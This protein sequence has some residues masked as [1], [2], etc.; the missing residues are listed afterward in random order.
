MPTEKI[1]VMPHRA[2]LGA[3]LLIVPLVAIG[4]A[5]AAGTSPAPPRAP[6]GNPLAGLS[7]AP[8]DLAPFAGTVAERL[9][10]GGY[11]YLR[12]LR[13]DGASTWTVTLGSGAKV[14]DRVAVKSY[15]RQTDFVSGRLHRTFPDLVF[16]V[17]SSRPRPASTP[18]IDEV[19]R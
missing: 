17:V 11:T 19:N 5:G 4:A 15:G 8:G 9:P 10:A 12:V 7:R 14:G 13:E 2:A 3:A 6:A 1:L 16:G 18:P